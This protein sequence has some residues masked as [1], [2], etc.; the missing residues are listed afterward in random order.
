MKL[1]IKAVASPR[2]HLYRTGQSPIEV[3][4]FCFGPK[5][6][7]DDFGL[8]LSK[9]ATLRSVRALG[10]WLVIAMPTVLK[11]ISIVGTAAM[12]WVGGS[13]VI[14]RLHTMHLSWPY[15]TITS[16]RVRR[17]GRRRVHCGLLAVTALL[18]A[19]FG[20]LLGTILIAV[21]NV[22]L[23]PIGVLD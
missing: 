18:D 17:D 7:L 23:V 20:F 12:L 21:V 19:V 8:Y 10:R 13:I 16:I 3:G 9:A 14:H 15:D 6:K 1:Q 11:L 22:L 4:L 2:N 5:A